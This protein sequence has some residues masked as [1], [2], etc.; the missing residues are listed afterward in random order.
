MCIIVLLIGL[1]A[2]A[3]MGRISASMADPTSSQAFSGV[4]AGSLSS[5]DIG[6]LRFDRGLRG[7]RMD[8]V[9]EVI[10]ALGARLRELE[11]EVASLSGADAPS[12]VAGHSPDVIGEESRG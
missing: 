4:P 11:A 9:D 12:L 7:Y 1:T 10:D 3:F 5:D 6:R 2:A 8:Q